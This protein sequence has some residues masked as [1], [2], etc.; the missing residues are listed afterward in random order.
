LICQTGLLSQLPSSPFASFRWRGLKTL[1]KVIS[2]IQKAQLK[3]EDDSLLWEIPKAI[4]FSNPFLI[5]KVEK[6]G[7]LSVG[8]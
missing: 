1:D 2:N 8:R 6:S 5:K 4:G 3:Y 7:T